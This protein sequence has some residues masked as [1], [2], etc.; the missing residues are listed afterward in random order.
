[1]NRRRAS[2]ERGVALLALLAVLV[3]GATWYL[4]SRLHQLS[5]NATAAERARNARVLNQAKQALIGYVIAQANHAFENNP[6]ALPCPEAPGSF[7]ATNGTDGKTNT[8]GCAGPAVGRYPWRTIGTDKLV[9]AAG[10]PLWYVISAGWAVTC[11][12]CSTVVNSNS[13]GQL[14]IDGIASA[15]LPA[16]DSVV[17]LII[18]PGPAIAVAAAPGCPGWTQTRPATS[19]VAPDVR[20]YLECENASN[21]ADANFVTGGPSGSFNDQV[22]KITVADIMPGIEAAV[23]DRLQRNSEF[24]ATLKTVSK[25]LKLLR[26]RLLAHLFILHLIIPQSIGT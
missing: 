5:A 18:A 22:V 26:W 3:L 20:N 16:D 14:N 24:F 21:P 11:S 23:A 7:N 9:D 6:G 10:E 25:I 17:A 19:G 4:V 12:A 8:G 1:M 2:R 13:V 15:A